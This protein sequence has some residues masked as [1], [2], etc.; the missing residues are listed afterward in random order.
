MF[1]HETELFLKNR[2]S[3]VA[4]KRKRNETVSKVSFDDYKNDDFV[5]LLKESEV[6]QTSIDG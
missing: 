3:D 1:N 6:I 5:E 4:K 2:H